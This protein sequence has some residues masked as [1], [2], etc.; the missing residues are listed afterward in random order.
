[1]ESLEEG[2]LVIQDKKIVFSNKIFKK[3]VD[4]INEPKKDKNEKIDM[5][6]V[7]MFKLLK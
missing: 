6:D 1:M 7:K 3:F 5:L 2:I 4:D